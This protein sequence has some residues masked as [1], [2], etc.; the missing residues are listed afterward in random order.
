MG[1]DS[2]QP[3]AKSKGVRREAE[4]EGSWRQ[5]SDLRNT[6]RIRHPKWDKPAKQGKIQ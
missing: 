4:S 2:C 1:A 5:N 6:N 3:L